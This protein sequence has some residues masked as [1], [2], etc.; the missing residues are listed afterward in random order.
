MDRSDPGQYP[1]AGRQSG[2]AM[3][4]ASFFR[5]SVLAFLVVL[6]VGCSQADAW[7]PG[8]VASEDPVQTSSDRDDWTLHGYD[9]HAMAEFTVRARVLSITRYH[10]GMEAEISPEDLA[11]GWGR[12]SDEVVLSRLK[13]SQGHRWY[14]YR[15][16][17]PGPPIPL[18]EIIRSS[19]NM[20]MVP[21]N[22]DVAA[23]LKDVRVGQVVILRGALITV[24]GPNWRW[25]SSTTRNDSGNGACELVWVEDIQTEDPVD[26]STVGD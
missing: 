14:N 13:I 23:L 7:G 18:S 9:V 19:A 12:M 20:H 4:K 11:L 5:S 3:A 21:A 2:S 26:T 24:K 22:D 8:V 1:L 15:W 16:G 6:L 10:T 17:P 25:V